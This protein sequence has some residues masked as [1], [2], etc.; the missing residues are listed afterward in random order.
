LTQRLAEHFADVVESAEVAA[1]HDGDLGS[2]E[3]LQLL[4]LWT[5]GLKPATTDQGREPDLTLDDQWVAVIAS[6]ERAMHV[7][8]GGSE[9]VIVKGCRFTPQGLVYELVTARPD[10]KRL[11][12]AGT[13]QPLSGETQMVMLN[14]LSGDLRPA[15]M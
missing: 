9:E 8:G 3:A 12:P 1:R 2:A 5:R 10:V 4:A 7:T 11:V 6:G 13:L 14:L 15:S